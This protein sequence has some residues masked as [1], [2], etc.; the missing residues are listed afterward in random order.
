ML[1][2]DVKY[3]RTHHPRPFG[4]LRAGRVPGLSD[5]P[6]ITLTAVQSGPSLR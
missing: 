2:P 5:V 3:N 6:A 4:S 1:S